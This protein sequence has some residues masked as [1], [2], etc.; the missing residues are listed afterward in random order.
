[1]L[2]FKMMFTFL[3][4]AF[5]LGTMF[6]F[7]VPAGLKVRTQA[8]WA[9][10]LLVCAMKFLCYG[11]FGGD[12]FNPELPDKLMWFW[13]WAY[14]GMVIL[15]IIAVPGRLV[16]NRRL[17]VWLL[18]AIAWGLSAV[19]VYNGVKP[20]DLEYV[21]LRFENLPESLDGYRIVHISDIH[22]SAAARRW[23]T[24][25]LV[26]RANAADGDLV[27]LTGDFADGQA[28][29]QWRNLEPIRNLK[30]RDGVLAVTGNHEYI[31]DY[32]A[33]QYYYRLWDIRFLGNECAFPRPGLAVGGVNDDMSPRVGAALPDLR[34]AFAG[35]TNG[36]FRVL[37]Q[38]RPCSPI[39][40]G[41][42]T[43]AEPY[44][45]QL[46]GHTHGGVAP[47]LRWIVQRFN[48]GFVKGAHSFNHG[49][50][51]MYVSPGAGQWAGFPVRFFNDPVI[52]VIT[53]RRK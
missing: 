38:H 52:T 43:A 19:G 21:E 4:F 51:L 25:A 34:A 31:S 14:S 49:R 9:M 18:P 20:P 28:H 42:G 41:S 23:R 50:S 40:G 39:A 36:E 8:M 32:H 29:R 10:A 47:V 17:R 46:S 33:W 5:A 16:R 44:D 3:P 35:A 1:M 22:A 11:Y 45:L 26:E 2:M 13:N 12:T 6:L 37:L 7:V 27:C 48:G 30:A 15:L 24:E 53:L